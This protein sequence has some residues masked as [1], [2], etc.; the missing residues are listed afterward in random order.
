ML[1][2]S[3]GAVQAVDDGLDGHAPRGVRFVGQKISAAHH[4]VVY[5]RRQVARHVVK[6]CSV[7]QHAMAPA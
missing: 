4:V 7:Q 3:A 5:G 1:R 6:S 2:A